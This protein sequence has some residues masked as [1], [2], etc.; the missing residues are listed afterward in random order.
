MSIWATVDQVR[1]RLTYGELTAESSPSLNDV[2]DWLDE[3]EARV[4]G[5][6]RA[7]GLT[8]SYDDADS[9]LILRNMVVRY[10]V[11][12]IMMSWGSKTGSDD[13]EAGQRMVEQF[14]AD[15]EKIR[16]HY[17]QL[18]AELSSSGSVTTRK[19]RSHVLDVPNVVTTPYF[20][21]DEKF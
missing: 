1:S 12:N 5:I 20:T 6:L 14:E 9:L 15:L 19:V 10:A 2:Q 4:K 8:T 13:M 7:A 18:G 11:G 17:V 16:N 3:A 21:M